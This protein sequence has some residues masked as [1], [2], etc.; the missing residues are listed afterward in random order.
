MLPAESGIGE[1]RG[2]GH[3]PEP[4]AAFCIVPSHPGP[5]VPF[6]LTDDDLEKEEC[7]H[8]RHPQFFVGGIAIAPI[9]STP[10]TWDMGTRKTQAVLNANESPS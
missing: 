8:R 9:Q 4:D 3:V 5:A 7:L 6:W 1:T 10:S 2:H